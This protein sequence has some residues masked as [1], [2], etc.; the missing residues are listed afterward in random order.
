[1]STLQLDLDL[2]QRLVDPIAP[3]DQAVVDADDEQRD[4][5]DDNEQDDPFQRI[6]PPRRL[7]RVARNAVP[8][9][10]PSR[11]SAALRPLPRPPRSMVGGEGFE[12]PTAS[13]Y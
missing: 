10:L 2:G 6:G 11:R 4:R 13:V 5:A 3:A 9:S 1:M 8:L 12:P 7:P